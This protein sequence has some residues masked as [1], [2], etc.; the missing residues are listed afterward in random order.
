MFSSN[1]T[2]S[3]LIVNHL[4]KSANCTLSPQFLCSSAHSHFCPGTAVHLIYISVIW[5]V[6][7]IGNILLLYA[8]YKEWKKRKT[9]DKV[10]ILNL[11]TS[12]VAA[13]LVSLPLH[14]V[15]SANY[16]DYLL[17]TGSIFYYYSGQFLS[18]ILWNFVTLGTLVVIGIDRYE[19]LT[20]FPHQRTL[21]VKRSIF[22]ITLV[23]LCSIA[24]V[25]LFTVTWPTQCTSPFATPRQVIQENKTPYHAIR[26]TTISIWITVCCTVSC[27]AL[28]LAAKRIRKHRQEINTMFG[29]V[30]AAAQISFTN[31]VIALSLCYII[32]WIPFGISTA[33]LSSDKHN[34][35]Y[36]CLKLW[37]NSSCYLSFSLLPCIYFIVDN[38]LRRTIQPRLEGASAVTQ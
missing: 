29:P 33:L 8:D 7:V 10:L 14:A 16:R 38:R 30:Q 34:T 3:S 15:V 36:I 22:A 13:L 2:N 31:G 20:K 37:T 18:L 32:L 12:N 6:G 35:T 4:N 11:A 17:C 1:E 27:T 9:P 26:I 25:V 5:A 28:L 23:W 21:D 19:A 24:V